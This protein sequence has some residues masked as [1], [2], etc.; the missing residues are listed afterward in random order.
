MAQKTLGVLFLVGIVNA[1]CSKVSDSPVVDCYEG[2]IGDVYVSLHPRYSG[3]TTPQPC[4]SL[5][6]QG[7][8]G[9]T[10]N[11]FDD[12]NNNINND[13]NFVERIGVIIGSTTKHYTTS[14]LD[15]TMLHFMKGGQGQ[16][17]AFLKRI[18]Q[19]LVRR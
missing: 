7:P 11:Y 13:H 8:E 18:Q 1:A 2:R 14:T 17:D 3:C 9:I 6:V 16:Y 15:E 4:L 19:E 10:V 5:E 12:D